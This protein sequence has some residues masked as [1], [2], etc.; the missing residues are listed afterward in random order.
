MLLDHHAVP[1]DKFHTRGVE[2]G[3][4]NVA[5]RLAHVPGF[6]FDDLHSRHPARCALLAV[7]C[8]GLFARGCFVGHDHDNRNLTCLSRPRVRIYELAA[9]EHNAHLAWVSVCAL[10]AGGFIYVIFVVSIVRKIRFCV[11]WTDW[12]RLRYRYSPR[13]FFWV[14]RLF[15]IK[16]SVNI[17]YHPV[18]CPET[19]PSFTHTGLRFLNLL[20]MN[21][22]LWWQLLSIVWRF[23]A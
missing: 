14:Q 21:R 17:M 5:R 3:V 13:V 12:S 4:K 1:A 2:I 18:Q 20:I 22:V 19:L 8:F 10:F 11:Q 7:Q 15:G 6:V 9:D 16:A 23:D